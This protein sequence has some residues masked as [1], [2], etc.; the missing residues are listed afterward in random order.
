MLSFWNKK[1]RYI[2]NFKVEDGDYDA[3]EGI[4]EDALDSKFC[5]NCIFICRNITLFISNYAW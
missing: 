2:H 5:N 4:I 3:C 1:V